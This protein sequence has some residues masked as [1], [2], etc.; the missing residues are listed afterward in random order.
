MVLLRDF[1]FIENKIDTKNQHLFK[2][3]KD[4]LAFKKLKEKKNLIDIF[5]ENYASKKLYIYINKK[6]TTHI[7]RIYIDSS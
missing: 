6:E 5:K 1:N 3:T 4:K 2:I 7:D